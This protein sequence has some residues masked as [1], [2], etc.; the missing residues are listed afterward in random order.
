LS[1]NV[2]SKTVMRRAIV[3]PRAAIAANRPNQAFDGWAIATALV[4]TRRQP[5]RSSPAQR[6]ERLEATATEKKAKRRERS[7]ED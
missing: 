3:G 5:L 7:D 6:L 1:V 4:I 2:S